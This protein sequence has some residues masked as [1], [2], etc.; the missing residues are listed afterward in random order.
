MRDA[1]EGK[2]RAVLQKLKFTLLYVDYYIF[3][4]FLLYLSVKTFPSV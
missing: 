3:I 2:G 1:K 4:W